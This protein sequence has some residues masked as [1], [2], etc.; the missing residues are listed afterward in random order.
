MI[1]ELRTRKRGQKNGADWDK[2]IKEAEFCIG[3]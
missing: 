3:L 1:A 2:S